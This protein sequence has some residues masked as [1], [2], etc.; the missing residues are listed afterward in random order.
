MLY[1]IEAKDYQGDWSWRNFG[2]EVER[3]MFDTLDEARRGIDRAVAAGYK[4]DN[5]QIVF[6]DGGRGPVTTYMVVERGG[7]AI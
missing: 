3:V 4:L 6:R 1:I 7:V 2:S 5:L